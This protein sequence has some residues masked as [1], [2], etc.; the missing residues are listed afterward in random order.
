[1]ARLME[2]HCKQLPPCLNLARPQ[3]RL[4]WI[5]VFPFIVQTMHLVI[6]K[7]T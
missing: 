2:I 3:V 5:L 7:K 4:R 6:H 1:M